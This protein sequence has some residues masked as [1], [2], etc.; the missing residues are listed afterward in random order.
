MESG[1]IVAKEKEK[2]QKERGKVM[3]DTNGRLQVE[4]EVSMGIYLGYSVRIVHV[5]E[6]ENKITSLL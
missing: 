4:N 1:P 2:E 3:E 5:R 6:Q